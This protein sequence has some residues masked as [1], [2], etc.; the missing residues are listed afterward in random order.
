MKKANLIYVQVEKIND[1]IG[2]ILIL[3]YY[4]LLTFKDLS[5]IVKVTDFI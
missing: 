3:F 5:I 1:Y 2:I 4:R